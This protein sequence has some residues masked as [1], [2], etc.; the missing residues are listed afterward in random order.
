MNSPDIQSSLA[1]TG[2]L[3][4][5]IQAYIREDEET[6]HVQGKGP[7]VNRPYGLSEDINLVEIESLLVDWLRGVNRYYN[8]MA[9]THAKYFAAQFRYVP[10]LNVFN[11]QVNKG[12]STDNYNTKYG[13]AFNVDA[14]VHP[15]M[16]SFWDR[17]FAPA[18]PAKPA[19][20]V[21]IE[22]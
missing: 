14:S 9:G 4:V 6:L 19:M 13:A 22:D 3:Y 16:K 1:G 15:K 17:C 8:S 10:S 11:I 20:V 2:K 21:E 18:S 5:S 12:D 7:D